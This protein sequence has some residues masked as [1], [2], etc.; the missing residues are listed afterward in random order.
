MPANDI[1]NI[2]QN[3]ESVVTRVVKNKMFMLKTIILEI[4]D[5]QISK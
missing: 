5:V 2:E 3:L 4:E 1:G